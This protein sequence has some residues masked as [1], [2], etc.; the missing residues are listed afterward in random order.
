MNKKERRRGQMQGGETFVY[1]HTPC[2]FTLW[3]KFSRSGRS[4]E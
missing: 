4:G 2:V 1:L 3:T